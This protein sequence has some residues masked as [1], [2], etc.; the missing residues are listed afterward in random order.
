[1]TTYLVTGCA[2]F[3]GSHLCDSLLEDGHSVV[4][5]DAFTPTYPRSL[6]ERNLRDALS[7]SRFRLAELDVAI[8]D[9]AL[10]EAVADAELVFHL[11][12]QPGVRTSWGASF[13]HYVHR[14]LLA[15]QRVFEAAAE[16]GLRVVL[17]SSS[18]VYGDVE[19]GATQESAALRPISPYGVTKLGCEHLARA[20]AK[21]FDLDV[22]TLRYFTVF[23]PRQ[24]PDMAFTRIAAAVVDGGT[25]FE[26]F[27]SGEQS[28][29]FT[30][31]ADAV[32]ATVLAGE[33]APSD[34]IYNVG[35]GEEATVNRV[36]ELVEEIAGRPVEILRTQRMRG[37]V[38]RT[39][40]DTSALRAE[41][42][43]APSVSLREGLRAQLKWYEELCAELEEPAT[44]AGLVER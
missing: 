18:S 11:A 30:Y 28:R 36:L 5:V 23:G 37:D 17:A 8:A 33:H 14:N 40:A 41:C 10:V 42:S 43:W 22:V 13:E 24:R 2:G 31:V 39:S 26:V 38:R 35:G 34:S 16:V 29:D 6:K 4:G 9:G 44:L 1:V 20:Y 12:A 19:A 32:A 15:T 25:P 3:I 21:S 7:N 27:G